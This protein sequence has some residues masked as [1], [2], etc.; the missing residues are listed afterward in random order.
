MMSDSLRRVSL[1]S[2]LSL[3][4]AVSLADAA[5]PVRVALVHG[6]YGNFRH[7]DDYD[8]VMKDLGWKLDKFENKDFGKLVG[9][10]EHYD[11]ILGTA[12]FNYCL[13]YTSDA[14]DE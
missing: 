9:Q 7:R 14:A 2:L 4:L 8:G 5:E 3:A 6:S 1:V 10:L 12:L 13:L 11:L